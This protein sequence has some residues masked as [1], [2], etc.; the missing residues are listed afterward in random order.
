MT[1]NLAKLGLG[2]AQF[3]LSYGIT[4]RSGRVARTSAHAIL[5]RASAAGFG[6][7]DTAP[8]YGNSEAVIGE[9]GAASGLRM[10]TKTPK[11]TVATTPSEAEEIVR[12]SIDQSLAR[13]NVSVLDSVLV[14]DAEDLM[15]PAGPAVWAAL[16][17]A[18]DDGKVTRI[19]A[20]IY[21]GSQIEALVDRYPLGILQI[22]WNPMDRRLDAQ[23][24]ID[25]LVEGGVAIHV[26]S[27]FLQGLILAGP[28]GIP[29]HLAPLRNAI[30]EFRDWA[31]D[32]GMTAVEAV[33]SQAMLRPEFE[34]C[35]VGVTSLEELDSIIAAATKVSENPRAPI[36]HPS[37]ALEECYLDPSQWHTLELESDR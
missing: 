26:R 36:F 37:V 20:S 8:V 31:A 25:W 3:G 15:G 16:E 24:L 5:E 35:L 27:L 11:L 1:A 29:P 13:L 7:V 12:I 19:G 17:R 2:G 9:S 23:S 22:P 14:H 32:G 10:V 18:K 6:F 28:S 34:A 21:R 4:N 30:A 33:L